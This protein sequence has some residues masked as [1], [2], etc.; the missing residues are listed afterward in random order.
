[1][2]DLVTR[3]TIRIALV[4]YVASLA[5]RDW[6]RRWSRLA[7][8]AGCGFY[9][10]HVALAFE[11]FHQWS[12]VEAYAATARQT[13]QVVG[14]DWG[15]GLYVNY[16]FTLVWFADAL[17]WWVSVESH[18]HRSRFLAWALDGFMGFIAFNA[19]VVFARGWSR[20]FGIAAC[21][22]LAMLW[23]FGRAAARKR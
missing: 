15:G 6:S 17:W 12:H 5:S 3:W 11:F 9:L 8:T 2:G 7:W 10:L 13:A 1:M 23:F 20:W 22:G 18:S 19:T 14:L 16:A 21:V 4:L